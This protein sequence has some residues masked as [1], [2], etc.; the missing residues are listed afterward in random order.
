MDAARATCLLRQRRGCGPSRGR[1]QVR[2]GQK[3]SLHRRSAP[4]SEMARSGRKTHDVSRTVVSYAER[5][6]DRVVQEAVI[7]AESVPLGRLFPRHRDRKDRIRLVR[8]GVGERFR[9]RDVL[10]RRRHVPG[11]DVS[12]V[13]QVRLGAEKVGQVSLGLLG[14]FARVHLRGG[15]T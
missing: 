9:D 8:S 13:V 15:G 2:P 10:V 14:I 4:R 1:G 12:N 7:Q 11:D 5:D 6:K 3:K